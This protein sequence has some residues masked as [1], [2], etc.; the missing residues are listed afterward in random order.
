MNLENNINMRRDTTYM[1]EKLAEFIGILLGDGSIGVYKS[2]NPEKPR[3][4]LKITLNSV[5]DRAYVDYVSSLIKDLFSIE[6]LIYFR[7]NENTADIILLNENVIKYLFNIGMKPSPK[8]NTAIIPELFLKNTLALNVL[9]GY[10]DTDGCITNMNN[11]GTRYPRIEM[12][13]CPS[14]M[15]T[16]IV[17]ILRENGFDPR[18]N[19]IGK[20]K[21]RIML[22]GKEKLNRWHNLIGFSNERNQKVADY[23]M[24]EK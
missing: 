13:I 8:W 10:M 24:N 23:F 6:P 20:G 7:K 18:V 12:K 19:D 9:R 17:T 1:D 2:K 4:R 3:Y 21:V 16:Q 14:P 15:Q 11:N 5:K 22:S